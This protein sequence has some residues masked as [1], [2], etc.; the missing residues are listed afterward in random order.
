MITCEI[1]FLPHEYLVKFAFW[2]LYQT[3]TFSLLPYFLAVKNFIYFKLFDLED[4]Q[5]WLVEDGKPLL[6]I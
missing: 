2:I 3:A 5:A 1:I 4:L 6:F